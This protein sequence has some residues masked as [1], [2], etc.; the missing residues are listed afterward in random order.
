MSN[1]KLSKLIKRIKRRNLTINL[2][3]YSVLLISIVGITIDET[4]M[5]DIGEPI[6]LILVLLVASIAVI[7][8][9]PECIDYLHDGLIDSVKNKLND[10]EQKY[11]KEN[12]KPK[13]GN[14]NIGDKKYAQLYLK[15]KKIINLHQFCQKEPK[16]ST[17]LY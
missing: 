7:L 9:I 3:L 5:S 17:S 8:M 11:L 16:G 4:Y 1:K 10:E 15:M 12:T 13:N 2:L 14:L 6:L